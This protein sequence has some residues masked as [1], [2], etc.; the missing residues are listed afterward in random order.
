MINEK[1][2]LAAINIRKTYINML[3]DLDKYHE[4]AKETLDMLNNAYDRLGELEKDMKKEE[5]KNNESYSSL[6]ELLKVINDI[7]IEGK[8]LENFTN[9]INKEIEKLALEEQELYKQICLNHPE[10]TEDQIVECVKERLLKEN[11]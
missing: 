1:F 5:N 11:L 3:S 2:L 8:K 6:N 7:E 10:L 9:P 4:K